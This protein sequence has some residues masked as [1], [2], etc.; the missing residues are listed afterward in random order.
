MS[1]GGRQIA[2]AA[3]MVM[4]LFA[5]SR[6]LG[7]VRQ[8]IVAALFGTGPD[9]DAFVVANQIPEAVFLIVGGGALGS[10]FIPVFADCLARDE[11]TRAW[12]LASSITNLVVIAT[13][14]IA[15]LIA[16]FAPALVQK[17]LAPGFGPQQQAL[18]VALLRVMLISPVVF[19]VSGIVMGTLN[20]QQH[21]FLPALAASIYNA[22]IIGGAL[23][24]QYLG[25]GVQG[26]AIGVVAGSALH[27]L[28]QV[29]MLPRYGAR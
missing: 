19:G 23:L 4:T 12:R 13:T 5:L 8:A 29:P 17:V 20:A 11:R 18:T 27:L 26:I 21:F 25:M 24:G 28:I 22:S 14:I 16:L 9:L 3:V 6:L 10:A 7:I 1:K 2:K 15:G